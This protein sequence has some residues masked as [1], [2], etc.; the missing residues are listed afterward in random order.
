MLLSGLLDERLDLRDVI[1]ERNEAVLRHPI[2]AGLVVVLARTVVG[3]RQI[4][5][6]VRIR[7]VL[8]AQNERHGLVDHVD[9]RGLQV[10]VRIDVREVQE[11]RDHAAVRD[12]L[13]VHELQHLLEEC[14]LGLRERADGLTA[15]GVLLAVERH[16]RPVDALCLA[17]AGAEHLDL[18]AVG[19]SL[20]ARVDD[21]PAD[22]DVELAHRLVRNAE[23][24]VFHVVV[25]GQ[26]PTRGLPK[27]CRQHRL[28]RKF[29][30]ALVAQHVLRNHVFVRVGVWMHR[31]RV[32]YNRR[33]AL[34]LE[35]RTDI[36][37]DLGLRHGACLHRKVRPAHEVVG[38]LNLLAE[39]VVFVLRGCELQ[40]HRGAI[41]AGKRRVHAKERPAEVGRPAPRRRLQRARLQGN[42]AQAVLG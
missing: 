29:A 31:L 10:A 25:H 5:T 37:V 17:G 40:C 6:L 9:V 18:N 7:V 32:K 11:V 14:R 13:A 1:V 24:R 42:D 20:L 16:L 34:V 30:D 15:E 22:V 26:C 28:G 12:D 27:A 33:C 41:E 4:E 8:A 36:V 19:R 38:G 39:K 23:A 35:D 21:E 2:D 3:D